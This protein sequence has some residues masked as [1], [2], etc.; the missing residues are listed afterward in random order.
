MRGAIPPP[1]YIFMEWWLEAQGQLANMEET[2]ASFKI[3][4]WNIAVKNNPWD[5]GVY[6]RLILEYVRGRVY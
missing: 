2:S 3:F 4:R 6:K 1:Q 5:P